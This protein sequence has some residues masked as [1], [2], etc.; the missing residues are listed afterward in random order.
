MR[1]RGGRRDCV[2]S[3]DYLAVDRDLEGDELAREITEQLWRVGDEAEGF[4]IVRLVDHLDAANRQLAGPAE[5]LGAGIAAQQR[6]DIRRRRLRLDRWF[7][8]RLDGG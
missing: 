1:P 3:P 4:D 7:R 2:A 8:L 6:A 5:H